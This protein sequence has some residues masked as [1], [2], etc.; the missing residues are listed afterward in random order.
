MISDNISEGIPPQRNIL[1]MVIPIL[2]HFCACL[3]VKSCFVLI[4]NIASHIK[5][6]VIQRNVTLL[7]MPNF[8]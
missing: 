6:H 5:P 7:M 8:F 3:A 1:N 4:G 2:M